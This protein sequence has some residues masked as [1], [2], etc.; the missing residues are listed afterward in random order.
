MANAILVF[1]PG[2]KEIT[3]LQDELARVGA[4]VDAARHAIE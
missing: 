2:L 3:A 4:V 1:L